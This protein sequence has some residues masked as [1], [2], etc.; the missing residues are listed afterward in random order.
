MKLRTTPHGT[1][2]G[3]DE[4]ERRR[5]GESSSVQSRGRGG[6][7][8]HALGSL[9]PSALGIRV[10]VCDGFA[11][12]GS[13]PLPDEVVQNIVA[14]VGSLLSTET[15][16]ITAVSLDCDHLTD[17]TSSPES[18]P[19]SRQSISKMPINSRTRR[20]RLSPRTVPSSLCYRCELSQ[21]HF[22][23]LFWTANCPKLTL[24]DVSRSFWLTD[25][26]IKAIATNCPALTRRNERHI[27]T[28]ESIK[29]IATNC[30]SVTAINV[31]DCNLRDEGMNAIPETV[32]FSKRGSCKEDEK[33][34][35]V[36][37]QGWRDHAIEEGASPPN[38]CPEMERG[39]PTPPKIDWMACRGRLR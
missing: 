11:S 9:T 7:D 35:T 12:G 28:D 14:Q 29:A 13:F 1:A 17:S 15:S 16:R 37:N 18:V 21:A 32:K 36:M 30:P 20:S 39:R 23:R 4:N 25:E 8:C 19:R 2:N 3:G 22:A 31:L 38:C 10:V 34:P 26:A 5:P 24:L 6:R 27:L 33:A